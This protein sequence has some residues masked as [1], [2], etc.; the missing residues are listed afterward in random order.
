MVGRVV[1]SWAEPQVPGLLRLRLLG[2]ADHAQ[3]LVGEVLGEVVAVLGPVR[4]LDVAVVLGEVRVPLVG[5]AADEPVEA[6]VAQPEGPV[7]LRRAHRPRVDRRVVVL[8]DPER[9]PAGVAQHGRHGGV[10]TRDVGVVAGEPGRGLGD[11]GEPVLMVV[12]PGQEHRTRRRAQRGRVPLRVGEPVVGQSLQCRHLD[13]S[14]ERRPR[15][16]SRVVEQDD[17][18]VR[19]TL[20][21]PVGQERRPVG[22]GVPDVEVDDSL[23]WLRHA[24]PPVDDRTNARLHRPHGGRTRVSAHH[25]GRVI[26]CSEVTSQRR[27]QPYWRHGYRGPVAGVVHR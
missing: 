24:A 1:G 21:R 18:H 17:E 16:E 4:L 7:L 11:R 14:T 12:A 3:R 22:C 26:R 15:G 8:A 27:A 25:P 2:V 13:A 6:V 23:E 10:L 5:L 20:G 19:R 9:A